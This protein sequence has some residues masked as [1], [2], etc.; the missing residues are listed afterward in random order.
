MLKIKKLIILTAIAFFFQSWIPAACAGSSKEEIATFLKN[1]DVLSV[2]EVG[3]MYNKISGDYVFNKVQLCVAEKFKDYADQPPDEA[4][5]RRIVRF[6]AECHFQYFEE[7]AAFQKS[8]NIKA[9]KEVEKLLSTSADD[10]TPD[11]AKAAVT[12]V[13][14]LLPGSRKSHTTKEILF[15][16]YNTY[17]VRNDKEHMKMFGDGGIKSVEEALEKVDPIVVFRIAKMTILLT[18]E[19]WPRAEAV[20]F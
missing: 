14:N 2:W 11:A 1:S 15:R 10:I 12:S 16:V 18:D 3:R 6:S 20:K 8:T 7:D 4:R 17:S 19:V 5:F 9:R 13:M